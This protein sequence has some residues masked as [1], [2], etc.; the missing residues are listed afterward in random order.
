MKR[1]NKKGFT[2]V[3]LLAAIVI[4][5][6]LMLVGAQAVAGIM[7]SSK[8][9]SLLSSLDMAAKQ[10]NTLL[11]QGE[12]KTTGSSLKDVLNYNE[13][14]YAVWSKISADGNYVITSIT[15]T[16]DGGFSSVKCNHGKIEDNV[17]KTVVIDEVETKELKAKNEA[18]AGYYCEV[19][20]NGA[21]ETIKVYKVEKVAN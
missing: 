15:T 1:L 16:A 12:L 3:E 19:I 7:R 21:L 4:L 9:N 6:V 8:A 13:K 10:A 5:A 11:A 20:T 17:Y 2:L 18:E 14:D